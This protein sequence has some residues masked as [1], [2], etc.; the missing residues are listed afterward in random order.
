MP[1]TV[2]DSN[3]KRLMAKFRLDVDWY[4]GRLCSCVGENNGIPRTDHNCN[5]G[6]YY[7]SPVTIQAIRTQ[8]SPRYTNTPHGRIFDGGATFI[9]PKFIGNVEQTAYDRISFGDILVEKNRIKRNTDILTRGIRDSI[10]AFDVTNILSVYAL[11][12]RYLPGEDFTTTIVSSVAGKLTTIVWETGK[13]PASGEKYT[14][15]FICA[16]QFRVWED[17]G[18]DRG[19]SGDYFPKKIVC[20]ARRFVNPEAIDIKQIEVKEDNIWG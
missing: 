19:T 5:V 13:G 6:F 16:Q 4:E 10:F 1:V 20:V 2:I 8:V 17:A 11:N 3:I 15:E 9:I 14:V 7:G 18:T 12:V